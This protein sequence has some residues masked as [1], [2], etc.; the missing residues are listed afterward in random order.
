M[1]TCTR[2]WKW[3]VFS[4]TH[5]HIRLNAL[6]CNDFRVSKESVFVEIGLDTCRTRR[7][8]NMKK[9]PIRGLAVV[10]GS[11]SSAHSGLD[12]KADDVRFPC[13]LVLVGNVVNDGV[14]IAP[15]K[16]S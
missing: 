2:V 7:D 5:G 6:S 14:L 13:F 15:A 16:V 12:G 8:T 11:E 3:V 4:W 10:G 9:P 1:S